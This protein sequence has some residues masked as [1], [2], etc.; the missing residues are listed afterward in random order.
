MQ[1]KERKKKMDKETYVIGGLE[2]DWQ[3]VIKMTEEQAKAIDWFIDETDVD[4]YIQKAS[5]VREEI[6]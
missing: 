5:E 6:Q 1:L 4:Y 3:R 2:Y